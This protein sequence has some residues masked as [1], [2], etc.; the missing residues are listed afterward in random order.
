MKASQQ[1][2][3]KFLSYVLRHRPDSIGLSLDAEG[4]A[5]IDRLI[6]LAAATKTPLTRELLTEVVRDND[7]QRFTISEDQ[8][9]I[10]ANQGHS[11]EI[12]LALPPLE[13]PELLYHGTATRFLASIRTE[14]LRRGSRQHVHLSADAGTAQK[15]GQRHG[16]PIVLCVQAGAM[17]RAGHT[18]HR[19]ENGVWLT[20]AVPPTFL[21]TPP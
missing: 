17:H 18:F 3:S 9:R 12:D 11:I 13:P 19:S 7:K 2:A 16:A 15:V 8:Q 5:V 6:E 14:G 4:W 10:R 21:A 20:A 1:A